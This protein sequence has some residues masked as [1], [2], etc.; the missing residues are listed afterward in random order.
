MRITSARRSLVALSALLLVS[1]Q[2][3]GDERR[4]PGRGTKEVA[5]EFVY[6]GAQALENGVEGAGIYQAKFT[7]PDAPG[8]VTNWY[9]TRLKVQGLEGVWINP[10][11]QPGIRI[12][13]ADDSRRPGASAAAVG[14]PRPMTLMVFV[15][16]T[17]DT[18]V[19]AVVSRAND[20]RET[21]VALTFVDN[22]SQ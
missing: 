1:A 8:K 7:T 18:V 22:T 17:N 9:R 20:E 15:K 16:K 19:T 10:G 11:Q 3:G 13:V 12:S 4:A 5:G 21:H 14:K 6:P 2:P